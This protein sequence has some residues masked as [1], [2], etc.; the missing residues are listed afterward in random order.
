M[1]ESA[2]LEL[3]L[4]I[5]VAPTVMLPEKDPPITIESAISPAPTP[6]MVTAVT[7]WYAA[8]SPPEYCCAQVTDPLV[9]DSC[10]ANPS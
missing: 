6:A 9:P 7:K 2:L 3:E 4:F 10:A 8:V 5:V 1:N